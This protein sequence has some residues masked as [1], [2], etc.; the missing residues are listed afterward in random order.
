[1]REGTKDRGAALRGVVPLR[2]GEGGVDSG[3][4]GAGGRLERLGDW[5]EECG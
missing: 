4:P 3:S 2:P 1:M 5:G